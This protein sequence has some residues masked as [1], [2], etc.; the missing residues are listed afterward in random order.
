MT[1][2]IQL[3]RRSAPDNDQGGGGG[4]YQPADITPGQQTPAIPDSI[5]KRFDELTAGQREAERRY[6]DAMALNQQLLAQV[7]QNRPQ[8]PVAPTAPAAP[9][10]QLPEGTDPALAAAFKAQGDYFAQMMNQQAEALSK[11]MTQAMGGVR[12]TTEQLRFQQASQGEQP[13]VAQL[14]AKLYQ[15]WQ[16]QG[17]TGWNPEDA[18]V[19]AKG[20]LFAQGKL[21][22]GQTQNVR[23]IN[24]P[25]GQM[26][27]GAPPPNLQNVQMLP[28]R[29]DDSILN[30][31]T[32]EARLKYETDRMVKTGGVDQAIIM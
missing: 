21:T 17:Y 8:A 27:F 16:K 4:T 26:P 1:S 22:P 31:M 30:K 3:Q 11:S 25:P 15:D 32:P 2:L 24:T 28:E 6:N 14:A 9:T 10:I 13:E 19:H 23:H 29:L 5:Q 12:Q 18:I 7:A 20:V